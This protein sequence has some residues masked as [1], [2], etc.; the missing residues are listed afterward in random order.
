M[1]VIVDNTG[2]SV[3]HWSRFTEAEF[4][5]QN[6]RQG[7]LKQFQEQDRRELL[8]YTYKLIQDDAARATKAAKRL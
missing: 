2:F 8:R 7:V 4:I 1:T 6:M 3:T 5:L